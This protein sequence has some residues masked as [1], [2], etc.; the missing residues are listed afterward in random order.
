MNTQNRFYPSMSTP[1]GSIQ[2][3]TRIAE[4]V[5]SVSTAGH[6]GIWLSDERIAQLPDHYEPFTG[7]RRW[8]EEDEDG[9]LV[10]QYL[11]FLSLIPDPLTLHVTEMDIQAGHRTRK[12]LYGDG[13]YGGPIAEAYK[14]QTGDNCGEMICNS[15]L[16]PSPGGFRLA[17]L[18]DDAKAWLK[19]FDAGE[20]VDPAIFVL[21]P[22]IV[23]ERVLF[24][25]HNA[26]G[27]THEDKVNGRTAK[28]ILAGDQEALEFYLQVWGK[29]CVKI[30]HEDKVIWQK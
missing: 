29:G 11:G 14:R 28:R 5:I 27:K 23:Y 9:A 7:T 25:R 26:E 2:T 21:E 8:A 4:G 22:Y 10:L 20:A 17:I 24:T 6:G 15:Y 13:F 3:Y 19:R 16:Q 18:P 12:K 1:W 30:T